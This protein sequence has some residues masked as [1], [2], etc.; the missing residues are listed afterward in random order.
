MTLTHSE[1]GAARAHD[2]ATA[3]LAALAATT[4]GS[5]IP[6]PVRACVRDCLVD[7]VGH[8]A[9]SA[10]FAESSPAFIAGTRDLDTQGGC[11]TVVGLS[12]TFTRQQATLLNGAFAHTMDFDDTNG[13]G[14]LHPGAPVIPA[15]LAEA[16]QRDVDGKALLDAIVIGY[17]VACRIGAALNTSAY[18]RG[19]HN[20]SVAGIFGAVAAAGRLRGMSAATIEAAFGIAGSLAS[21]SM[22]YLEN[23]AWNKRLHPGF[24]AHNAMLALSYAQAG[25]LAATEPIAGRFGLLAGYTNAPRPEQLIN[26]L[27]TQWLAGQTAL[28]PYP[29]CRLTHAAIDAALSLRERFVQ[30]ALPDARLQVTISPTAHKIVG[31]ALEAKLAPRNIV[32][33]QFSLYFQV[34]CA[35]LDGGVEWQSY[36]R[37]I[38]TAEMS[39]MTQ[40]IS[41][42]VDPDLAPGGCRLRAEADGG[43]R[44]DIEVLVPSGDPSTP[45]SPAGVRRKF[46]SLATPVYGSARAAEIADRLQRI[47]R[48]SSAAAAIASLRAPA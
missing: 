47:D 32:D 48:E 16:E 31:E 10:Q 20:T 12:E 3:A 21:G 19:F 25:V 13:A 39:A 29:S 9:F 34:A 23:G 14:V 28:K 33:A 6:E 44:H 36:E 46:L 18:E 42:T 4:A 38:G 17:E 40:R 35:W 1:I 37:R 30:G 27:G 41:V 24:A 26:G 5:A 22:Q 45:L 2:G 43:G 7:F 15:A 11:F 8:T